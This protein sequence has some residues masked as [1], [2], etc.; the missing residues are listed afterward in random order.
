MQR[1][2]DER[3]GLGQEFASGARGPAAERRRQIE[4]V[5]VFERMHQRA[6][7]IVIT[8]RGAGSCVGR[9]IGDR[10]HREEARAGIVGEGNAQPLAIRPCDEG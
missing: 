10:L 7:D 6:G 1:H 8:H 3:I 4:A 9:R 5:A 2:R